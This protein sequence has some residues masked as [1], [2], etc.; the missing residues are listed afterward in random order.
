MSGTYRDGIAEGLRLA[1]EIVRGMEAAVNERLEQG[2]ASVRTRDIR[3]TRAQ[4]YRNATGRIETRL[5]ARQ[6]TL[7]DAKVIGAEL[8]RLGL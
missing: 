1:A 2:S 4:A 3:K 5:R 7:P 6:G 8:S